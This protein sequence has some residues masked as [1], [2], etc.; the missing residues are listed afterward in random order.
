MDNATPPSVHVAP[1]GA[2][3]RYRALD[4]L[5][6]AAAL[7]VV[8]FHL[9]WPN[10]VTHNE[11]IRHGYLA[12]DLFFVLSGFVIAANYARRLTDFATAREFVYLR[13]F[14]VYPLHL[15]VLG[16]FVS[17]ELAKLWAAR[18]GLL[19]P[20]HA[21]FTDNTSV[22]A[23]IA[24]IL[25]IHSLDVLPALSWNSPSWSISCEFV[26]YILFAVGA[27]SLPFRNRAAATAAVVLAFLGYVTIALTRQSLDVTYDFGLVRCVCGFFLG[28]AVFEYSGRSYGRTSAARSWA[29]SPWTQ[30]GLVAALVLVMSFASGPSIVLIVPI[31]V[32]LVAALQSD[33]GPVGRILNARAMRFLG[34]ISYSIYMVHTLVL[35]VVSILLKRVFAV[36]ADA[37]PVTLVPVLRI[38]PWIGD[39][40]VVAVIGLV[41]AVSAVTYALVE[42]PARQYGRGLVSSL[43][44][45]RLASQKP[46]A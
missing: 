37:D 3:G 4:G 8:C 45:K 33:R 30:I 14:R 42:E 2:T 25:L 38:D 5:R 11:F 28:M 27:L 35:N 44:K 31:F 7:L 12:V 43:R 17:L 20:G 29:A 13:F 19:V 41:L 16:G 9:R 22:A 32:T 24:N 18:S 40:L 39:L 26:A 46:A 36:P 34:R 21:P 23:L 10:H 1:P 6:G 15:A